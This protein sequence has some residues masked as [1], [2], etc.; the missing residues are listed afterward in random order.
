MVE[1]STEW[2]VMLL[3]GMYYIETISY[4]LQILHIVSLDQKRKD[5]IDFQ[6]IS[7]TQHTY[8]LN[9]SIQT[10]KYRYVFCTSK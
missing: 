5:S 10:K 3:E 4:N 9:I 2:P 8:T 6:F 7:H 1:K